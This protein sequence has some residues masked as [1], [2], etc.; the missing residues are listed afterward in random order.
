[1]VVYG[2]F[3]K[4]KGRINSINFDIVLC[5]DN[6]KVVKVNKI[7]KEVINRIKVVM[8]EIRNDIVDGSISIVV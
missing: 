3:F 1:M 4:V 8:N 5:K 6:L 7:I 2:I